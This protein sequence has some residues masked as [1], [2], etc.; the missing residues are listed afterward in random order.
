MRRAYAQYRLIFDHSLNGILLN[1][2][3][4][5]TILAANPEA[6]RLL[7]RPEAELLGLD[8]SDVMDQTDPHLAL[9]VEERARTGKFRGEVTFLRADGTPLPAEVTSSIFKD[10][11]GKDMTVVF[12]ADISERKAAE[13][14]LRASETQYRL[15][16]DNSLVGAIVSDPATGEFLA[17]NPEACRMLGYAEAELRTLGR[18]ALIDIK[19]PCGGGHHLA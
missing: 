14:A 8:R 9:A 16:F 1:E 2:P 4:K 12:F 17:V 7:G 11:D 18:S 3:A 15:L 10:A 19:D 13:A 6:C 5:G